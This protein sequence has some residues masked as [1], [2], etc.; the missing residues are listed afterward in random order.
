MD[1][2]FI[3]EYKETG[4]PAE[5]LVSIIVITY[6]SAQ[7]VLETL[8]SAKGQTYAN[9]ELI[10]SDDCSNDSTIEICRKWIAENGWR[11]KR[12]E[13]LTIEYNTGIAPNCNR[14]V[15]TATGEWIKLI[16]GDDSLEY[17]I[18][19]K[20]IDHVK[21][22]SY[23]DC[24]YSNVREYD[25]LFIDAQAI[26]IK[27]FKSLKFNSEETNADDQFKLLLRSNCVWT[28]TLMIKREIITQI[29][30]FNEKYPFFE[31]RPL[32]L[33]LTKRGYKIYYLDQIG[34]K[35]R[36]HALSVQ[37]NSRNKVYFSKFQSNKLE[38]FIN[39]Y[40]DHYTKNEQ[41]ELVYT[42]RKNLLIKKMFFNH[43]NLLIVFISRILDLLPKLY[44]LLNKRVW[45]LQLL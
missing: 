35:Y 10:V 30:G 20:Y 24:L 31:D 40:L 9:I 39:E 38:F 45:K 37:S 6:N 2:Q 21:N 32:L 26:P 33:E 14:G 44:V 27:D 41:I 19:A 25:E 22:H 23:V 17:D 13:L 42:L 34:A 11:F 29:G 4:K 28:S 12:V 36:R 1:Q 7:Y 8:E 5:P 18:I 15:K 3:S 16:A 43:K